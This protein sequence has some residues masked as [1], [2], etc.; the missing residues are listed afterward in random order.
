MNECF[1]KSQCDRL[2]LAFF[3]VF[4]SSAERC[5]LENLNG[6]WSVVVGGV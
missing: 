6:P 5:T 4:V 1:T 2:L 3:F